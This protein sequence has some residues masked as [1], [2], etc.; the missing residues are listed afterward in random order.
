MV[1][2]LLDLGLRD[3]VA[4][5]EQSKNEDK[6]KEL[7]ITSWQCNDM[8]EA[9]KKAQERSDEVF[10]AVYLMKNPTYADAVVIGIGEKSFSVLLLQ[11]GEEDRLFVD[12]MPEGIVSSFDENSQTMTLVRNV[13]GAS[14]G[15]AAGGA[16]GGVPGVAGSNSHSN[17][18]RGRYANKEQGY[19]FSKMTVGI[20]TPVV[21]YLSA[22]PTPP[23]RM[24]VDLVCLGTCAEN[25]FPTCPGA[26]STVFTAATA[27]ATATAAAAAA[28]TVSATAAAAAASIS[29]V[30]A[31]S[32][33]AAVA[34]VESTTKLVESLNLM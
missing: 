6:L 34:D 31:S 22:K 1:H 7:K 8:R 3:P 18:N 26:D 20:L 4:A 21:V 13:N 28:A 16:A 32:T 2:R 19:Q 15:G 14:A 24:R 10:L 33:T 5:Q 30:A 27:T 17:F 9:A 23:I 25:S 12:E 29:L 11:F